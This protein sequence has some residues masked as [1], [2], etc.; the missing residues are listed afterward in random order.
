MEKAQKIGDIVKVEVIGLQDYGVFVKF[1]ETEE[2]L[3]SDEATKG[4]IHISEIQSGYVKDIRDVIK[5]GQKLTAQIIDIDEFNGK[6]S[7]SLRSLEDNP[8]VHHFFR[9]K[10]FTNPHDKIGFKSL[11]REL[12]NWILENESYLAA[13]E[14]EKK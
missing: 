7:L 10:H 12:P 14:Q 6:I 8:Q 5:N 11:E 1:I 3:K 2:I 13:R 4:L 9:K